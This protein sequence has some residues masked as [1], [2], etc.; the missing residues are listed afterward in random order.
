MLAAIPTVSKLVTKPLYF[1]RTPFQRKSLLAG[2]PCLNAK[3]LCSYS[4]K[5]GS[6]HCCMSKVASLTLFARTQRNGCIHQR[7]SI[8]HSN[9]FEFNFFR[10]VLLQM[11][12]S[13]YVRETGVCNK[14]IGFPFPLN[15]DCAQILTISKN[16]WRKKECTYRESGKNAS[17]RSRQPCSSIQLVK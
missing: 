4:P 5:I 7:F 11:P 10:S 14:F 1:D 13:F 2:Y 3:V 6:S 15:D 17:K 16:S 12:H 8:V 9:D